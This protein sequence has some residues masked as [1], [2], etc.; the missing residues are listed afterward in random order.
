M[1]LFKLILIS[2]LF[3]LAGC[4]ENPADAYVE[5]TG[6]IFIFNYRV[7]T[8]TYVVT[9]GKLR[10]IPEGTIVRTRFDNPAG[11]ERIVVEQKVWPKLE[12]IAIESPPVFCIVK[13]QPYAFEIELLG[14]GGQLL[15]K[16][17]GRVISS[18]DQTALPDRPLVVGPVY[19]PNPELAGRPNGKVPS[20][21]PIRCTP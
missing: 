1:K 7:A 4:R 17:D 21:P 5:I 10:P 8:A 6:K 12:K 19:T 3:V 13:D 16:L 18:L 20:G 11:G 15:Q 2:G 9:L 14:I